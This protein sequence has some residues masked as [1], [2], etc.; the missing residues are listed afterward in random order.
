M[1]RKSLSGF[2]VPLLLITFL[3]SFSTLA[4]G[5][6]L[7]TAGTVSGIVT[8][9]DNA[10]VPNAS[11]TIENSVTGYKRTLNTESDGSFKFIGVPPNTYSLTATATGFTTAR[12]TLNVRS[13]VP[14]SVTIPLS[15]GAATESVTVTSGGNDVLENIPTSHTDVDQGLIERL[16]MRSPGS[17]LS[18]VVTM[19]APGV[20]AES[21]GMFHPLGDQSQTTFSVD[22]QPISDQQSKAFSTQLPP[23]AVQSMEVITGATP[24]EY[25]DKTSLVVNVITKSGLGQK[26]PTGS[27]NVGYGSFGSVSPSLAL[28]YGGKK[29]GNFVT[30]N[31][32]RSGRFLDSPEFTALHDRGTSLS[33]FDRLDYS[34]GPDDTFHFNVSLAQNRFQIPNTFDQQALNQDQNQLVRSIN[35]AP[36]YVH[37]F[38]S[39]SVLTI[40][41]Y[42]RQDRVTYSPSAN[43]FADSPTT[44]S[45]ERRLTNAG[46][47]TDLSYVKGK[48]NAKFGAQFSHTFLTEDFQ[49]GITDPDFNDPADPDFVPGL[50]PF[51]L[52]RGGQRFSFN[53]HTDIKQFAAYA[54]DAITLKQLTLSL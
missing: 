37:I 42:F 8:D 24:A 44:I 22:N 10:V 31:F 38:N 9:P 45:Q 50:L 30:F 29:L 40:N 14:I 4:A 36:G 13:S 2:Q 28:A 39:N 35:L 54:Q 1:I 43:P 23:D 32:E 17:G 49:F 48:H 20:V 53:G 3:F 25:G 7:G 16:P 52:T 11:V 15:V 27:F 51:D 34:L 33:L 12:Q 19:A 6:A 21:N 47:R 18:D 26:K 41:P 46:L 5:Q